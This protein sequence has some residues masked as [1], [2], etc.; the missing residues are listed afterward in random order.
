[1][2]AEDLNRLKVAAAYREAAEFELDHTVLTLQEAVATAL[3]HGEDPELIAELTDLSPSEVLKLRGGPEG[4]DATGN[5][6]L[7][8]L[9]S[10]RIQA[11][12][13]LPT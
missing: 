6:L 7:S 2:S 8:D 1:M 10:A 11:S 13:T 4:E 12:G 5:Y 9:H 3:R